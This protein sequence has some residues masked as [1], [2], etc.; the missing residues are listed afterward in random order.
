M[1]EARA[2]GAIDGLRVATLNLLYYPQ[3]DRWRERRPLVEAQVAELSPDLLAL[4]E[5][6][7]L[8]DQDHA[9]AAA[10]PVRGYR[11]VRASETVP[12]HYPRHWDGVVWLLAADAGTV[13]A[14]DVLRLTHR[15]VVS[16]VRLRRAS[17]LTLTTVATHLQHGDG[18][19]G[20][21]TRRRQVRTLL[22]WL[23]AL[24]PSDVRLIVGDLNAVPSEPAIE[25]LRAAGYRSAYESVHGRHDDTFPSGLVAP[26][27]YR[28]PG[29]TIDYIWV[30]GRTS[31]TDAAITL[32]RPSASD[33]TLR[34]SDHRGV[35]ADLVLGGA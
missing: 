22:R 9:L 18:P 6:D 23:E 16:A 31:V 33:P 1:P 10:I 5:V 15:R 13:E 28:G 3:G 11:V 4:Q 2:V 14:T 34:P 12:R 29:S 8:I 35:V 32:D 26:T 19:S 20:Q 24:P 21:E 7:R 25:L 17:G 30:Q 27:I